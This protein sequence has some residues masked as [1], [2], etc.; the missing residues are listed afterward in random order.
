MLGSV[1]YKT[2]VGMRNVP[3]RMRI[4]S[5]E[6][7]ASGCDGARREDGEVGSGHGQI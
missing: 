2:G 1:V 6:R 3:V 5:K 4:K 7:T